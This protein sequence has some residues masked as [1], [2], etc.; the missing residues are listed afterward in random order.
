MENTNEVEAIDNQKE[1]QK[2]IRLYPTY[3]MFSW[4]LLFYY[5]IIFLFFT[6]IKGLSTADVMLAE[7]TYPIFK[8]ILM[9]P[10]TILIE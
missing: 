6:Q 7:A 2:N 8:F 10:S 5:A 1:K 3:K 4:D 9:I